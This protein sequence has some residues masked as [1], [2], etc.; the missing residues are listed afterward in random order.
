MTL[1]LSLPMTA[2]L[3]ILAALGVGLTATHARRGAPPAPAA[4]PAADTAAGD[5]LLP[6][7]ARGVATRPVQAESVDEYLDLPGL[8]EPDPARVVRVFPPVSG[9][10]VAVPV[11]PADRVAAGQVLAILASS[12]VAAARAAF[13]QAGADARVKQEQLERSG[14]LYEHHVIALRDYQQAQADEAEAAAAM[15][16]AAERLALLGVDTAGSSDRVAVTASRAGVVTDV[17]AAPGEYAKSLD[18]ASPLCTITDLDTV[19]AVGA[20]YEKDLASIRVGDRADVAT[21]AYPLDPRRARIV[22]ISS[23]VDSATRTL[24]VRVVLPNPGLRL[25]PAMFATIRV[26]RARQP[27]IV[28]PQTA[29]LREGTSAYVFV[30]TAPGRFAR[31]AVTLGPDADPQ[32]VEVVSGLTPGEV[33]VVE[34]ADL[35]LAAATAS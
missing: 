7:D 22:A 13:R 1:R 5:Y 9:R 11:R 10:L 26:L 31:R 32:R 23:A 21:S 6:A 18:N 16:S 20:V 33:V 25:K 30:Q 34:G 14:Q 24:Q 35:L 29:V 19:W 4:R 3:G 27:A 12:D 28:L 8:I 15:E 2:L 17:G